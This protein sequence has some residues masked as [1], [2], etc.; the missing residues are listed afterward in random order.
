[1][2]PVITLATDAATDP[3]AAPAWFHMTVMAVALLV[4]VLSLKHR[5]N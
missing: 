5:R 2:S 3:A 4:L 1:M